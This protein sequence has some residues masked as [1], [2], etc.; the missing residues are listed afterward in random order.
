[1]AGMASGVA[2]AIG[3]GVMGGGQ[4]YWNNQMRQQYGGLQGYGGQPQIDWSNQLLA[5]LRGGNINPPQ[6]WL[7][8]G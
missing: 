3:S 8:S 4:D 2:G 6:G 5:R 1:M 7:G